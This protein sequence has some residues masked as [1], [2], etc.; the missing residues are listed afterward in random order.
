MNSLEQTGDS[1]ESPDAAAAVDNGSAAPDV[2]LVPVE[3]IASWDAPDECIQVELLRA[4][5]KG[6]LMD[7]AT[8]QRSLEGEAHQT[9]LG[10]EI[11]FVV[12]EEGKRLG[13]R[14]LVLEGDSCREHD[15]AILLV[16][17]LLLEHGAP[18]PLISAEG[19]P[20]APPQ[21]KQKPPPD[22]ASKAEKQPEESQP[23]AVPRPRPIPRWRM[24]GG[25]KVLTGL[26]PR[27]QVGPF[28]GGGVRLSSILFVELE[29]NFL[30]TQ[31]I[32]DSVTGGLLEISSAE[33]SLRGCAELPYLRWRT[34]GCLGAGWLGLSARAKD[35]ENAQSAV[36]HSP[37][38]TATLGG[39]WQLKEPL[40]L[41]LVGDLSAPFRPGRFAFAEGENL[42]Q[43]HE[44]NQI[45]LGARVGV[46]LS[47]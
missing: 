13:Q 11:R 43:V 47:F 34:V 10:W 22:D 16:A 40:L 18:E 32:R 24:S 8:D 44:T 3:L 27:A 20:D 21:E 29:G 5:V 12:F 26:A 4:R 9:E 7:V 42:V 41:F 25:V 23:L 1:A 14:V 30:P 33:L 36:H 2:A 37:E 28:L 45:L 19:E 39:A 31:K 35:I 6:Q 46:A 17:G 38:V 15:D